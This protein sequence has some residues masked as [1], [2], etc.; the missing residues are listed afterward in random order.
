MESNIVTTEL[1]GGNWKEII[2][3]NRDL[4]TDLEYIGIVQVCNGNNPELLSAI[5]LGVAVGN[6]RANELMWNIYERTG[7]LPEVDYKGRRRCVAINKYNQRCTTYSNSLTCKKHLKKVNMYT[8]LFSDPSLQERYEAILRSPTKIQLDAEQAMMRLM[9][10][11]IVMKVNTGQIPIDL[12]AQVTILCE[13]ISQITEKM[14][15]MN[16]ITPE[17]IEK[18]FSGVTDIIAKY[19]PAQYLETVASEIEKLQPKTRP[20]ENIPF[21]PGDTIKIRGEDVKIRLLHDSLKE[22]AARMTIDDEENGI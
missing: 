21:T 16:E 10:S 11:E 5:Q 15:K 6:V 3:E 13:K 1:Q 22:Q 7:V 20:V 17:T 2:T 19:V 4:V 14:S 18:I 12:I 9:L 8:N